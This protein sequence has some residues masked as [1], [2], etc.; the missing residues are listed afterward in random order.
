MSEELILRLAD[1]GTAVLALL[2]LIMLIKLL[3]KKNKNSNADDTLY[4]KISGDL[5]RAVVELKEAIIELKGCIEM[6]KNNQ[7]MMMKELTHLRNLSEKI[8]KRETS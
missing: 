7:E 6:Q 3:D 2:T 4:I 1:Y 8:W 5:A